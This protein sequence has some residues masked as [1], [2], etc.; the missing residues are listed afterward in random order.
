[1][2]FHCALLNQMYTTDQIK[3]AVILL[4]TVLAA[5][6]WKYFAFPRFETEPAL[7]DFWIGT[8]PLF[9]ALIL[10]GLIPASIVKW[11]FRER[12]VDY[13]LRFGIA[14]RTIRSFLLAAPLIVVIAIL[15]G[16]NPAFYDVYP[17]NETIRPQHTKIGINLFVIYA[18]C[19]LGYYFGWEFLFRGFL[20]HGLSE[21]CGIPAAILIQTLASTMLHYG[22]PVSEVF[23]AIIA[24]L[25]WGF[26]AYRTR[27]IL[28]GLGQHVLLGIVLDWV[29]IF[30]RMET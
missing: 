5:T 24:G 8:I 12:L 3:P 30:G 14:H 4:Y 6:V 18:V 22:H 16:H 13:G 25:V 20:Q 19:Y 9:A 23:G 10:F 11:G 2:I 15:T 27:S 17:L 1:M 7:A 21:R 26:I 28:S 29:L